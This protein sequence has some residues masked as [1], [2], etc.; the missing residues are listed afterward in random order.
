MQI[1]A[2][3]SIQRSKSLLNGGT[4]GIICTFI[5]TY[6][7]I[8]QRSLWLEAIKGNSVIAISAEKNLT[9]QSS[10]ANNVFELSPYQR[11]AC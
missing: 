2:K 6:C 1:L 3:N 5:E 4:G 10:D 8:K 9:I 11:S 7:I